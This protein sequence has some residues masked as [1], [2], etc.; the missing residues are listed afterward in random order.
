MPNNSTR[1]LTAAFQVL[2]R[3]HLIGLSFALLGCGALF[4][5]RI[6]DLA[7]VSASV[8]N[9][10][11]RPDISWHFRKR[12]SLE[13]LEI[14]F[15][16]KADLLAVARDYEFFMTHNIFFCGDGPDKYEEGIARLSSI[17]SIGLGADINRALEAEQFDKNKT[18]K[19]LQPTPQGMYEY[20]I[21]I[22]LAQASIILFDQSIPAYDLHNPPDNLC[23]KIHG[24]SM[25]AT[26]F[27]SNIF[28]IPKEAILKAV[29]DSE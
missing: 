16:S 22:E 14:T 27:D 24:G 5:P 29:S 4:S 20:R 21:Y 25:I 19:L 10:H 28:T 15:N 8:V 11:D 7:F 2:L 23:A 17:H 6:D 3:A 18:K 12:R 13:L 26:Y 9:L 1:S